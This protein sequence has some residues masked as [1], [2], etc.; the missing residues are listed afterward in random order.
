[1]ANQVIRI[2]S[3]TPDDG[4]RHVTS[5]VCAMPSRAFF[6]LNG[7]PVWVA[8]A[9]R[10]L[11]AALAAPLPNAVWA[12][13]LVDSIADGHAH[14]IGSSTGNAV[15]QNTAAPAVE[16]TPPPT[17][18]A[19]TSDKPMA[20]RILDEQMRI[21]G[22]PGDAKTIERRLAA[23]EATINNL[24]ASLGWSVRVGELAAATAEAAAGAP[25]PLRDLITALQIRVAEA[26]AGSRPGSRH[27][28]GTAGGSR[29]EAGRG[30]DST[31]SCAE[32]RLGEG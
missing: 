23:I 26:A 19:A 27:R 20:A 7:S 10:W 5:S 31:R 12:T 21:I 29:T 18:E 25:G 14:P 4:W 22:M 16:P 3:R 13:A 28:D 30:S 15:D 24:L 2:S 17:V 8:S 32:G 1:M 9:L 6:E 11:D